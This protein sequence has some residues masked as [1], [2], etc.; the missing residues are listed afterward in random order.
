ML[1]AYSHAA[2]VTAEAST[3]LT[4]SSNAVER[5]KQKRAG[6]SLRICGLDGLV[7]L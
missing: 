6:V 4:T 2:R 7:H 5:G 3:S 1:G